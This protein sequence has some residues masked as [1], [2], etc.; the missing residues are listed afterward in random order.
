[1]LHGTSLQGLYKKKYFHAYVYLD[2]FLVTFAKKM[3]RLEAKIE[4]LYCIVGGGFQ[5]YKQI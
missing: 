4:N 5:L 3:F 1:M 2:E